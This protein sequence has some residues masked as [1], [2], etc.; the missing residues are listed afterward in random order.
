ML[1]LVLSAA[2]LSADPAAAQGSAPAT[3]A[4]VPAAQTQQA[5]A[6]PQKVHRDELLCKSE[7]VLGTL[8]PKKVCYTREQQE[9]RERQD[10][11]NLD[12]QQHSQYMTHQN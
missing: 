4:A 5:A 7:P 10:R 9:A 8:I 12:H 1:G 11:E 2:L 3:P 6:G